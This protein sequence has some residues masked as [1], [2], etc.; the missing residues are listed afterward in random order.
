MSTFE[1]D[2]YFGRGY[3]FPNLDRS[4]QIMA[5]QMKGV[6]QSPRVDR[7]GMQLDDGEWYNN[8]ERGVK[9]GDFN[10]GDEVAFQ[11]EDNE[12]NGK[13]WHNVKK[14]TFQVTKKAGGWK[15]GG[16]KKS[17]GFNDLGMKQGNAIHAASRVV[18]AS[19]NSGRI[20]SAQDAVK[21]LS[22]IA[23]EVMKI[24]PP[25]SPNVPS[26]PQEKPTPAPEPEKRVEPEFDGKLR[27]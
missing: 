27:F 25:D 10:K 9:L 19:I 17:G 26:K 20:E 21:A 23:K 16:Y 24:F 11:Y 5:L 13:V 14:G 18:A 22:W 15:P 1:E 7:A 4:R 6:V 3:F 8:A 12:N 2:E